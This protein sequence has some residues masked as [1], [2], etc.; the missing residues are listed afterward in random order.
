M[1]GGKG[2]GSRAGVSWAKNI[3]RDRKRAVWGSTE[4]DAKGGAP[5]NAFEGLVAWSG[6]L[7]GL[8]ASPPEVSNPNLPIEFRGTLTPIQG[9]SVTVIANLA[10]LE[11][12][13]VH[14]HMSL[15]FKRPRACHCLI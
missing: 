4:R 15:L 2:K 1:R 8:T 5:G 7:N 10:R 11:L 14:V 12:F 13:K 6:Q 9:A 3:R